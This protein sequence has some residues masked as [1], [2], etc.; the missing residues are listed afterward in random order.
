MEQTHAADAVASD[1]VLSHMTVADKQDEVVKLDIQAAG[2]S[3]SCSLHLSHLPHLREPLVHAIESGSLVAKIR[4]QLHTL[5]EGMNGTPLN[6]VTYGPGKTSPHVSH[7]VSGNCIGSVDYELR[8]QLPDTQ[9]ED[10]MIGSHTHSFSTM[11]GGTGYRISRC[12]PQTTV[13]TYC[14]GLKNALE[15]W[16]TQLR[17]R[18]LT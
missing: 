14:L 6:I 4:A 1:P 16:A 17:E 8:L 13:D 11:G 15:K 5:L 2:K 10:E 7:P 3:I 9:G 18:T 12:E